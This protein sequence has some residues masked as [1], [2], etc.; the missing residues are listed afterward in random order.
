MLRFAAEL[1]QPT[2]IYGGHEAY[3]DGAADLFKK[4]NTPVLLSLRWPDP[5][6]A[7]RPGCRAQYA[8]AGEYRQ[9]ALSSRRP[10]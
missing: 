7:D 4:Y 10:Q 1:K 8:H 9:G 2:I 5:G 6:A 3:R